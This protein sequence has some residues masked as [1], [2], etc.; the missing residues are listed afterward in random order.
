LQAKSCLTKHVPCSCYP[1]KTRAGPEKTR[2]G[3]EK[4]RAGPERTRTGPEKTPQI[5]PPLRFGYRARSP[6]R[7]TLVG[8]TL[9]TAL[10]AGRWVRSPALPA[11]HRDGVHR[12]HE[13][14]E[15]KLSRSEVQVTRNAEPLAGTGARPETAERKSSRKPSMIWRLNIFC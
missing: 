6:Q 2:A 1:E 4:T 3:P 5:H 9:L 10:G 11:G 13:V 8:C 7:F 15:A 12:T 14:P